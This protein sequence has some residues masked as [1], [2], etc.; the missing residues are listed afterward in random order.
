LTLKRPFRISAGSAETKRN[1]ILA[2]EK[3][4]FGEAAGSIYYGPSEEVIMADLT[5]AIGF[6]NSLKGISLS[7]I[8]AAGELEIHPVCR[9]ALTAAMLNNLSASLKQ[10][11]WELLG[12]NEPEK[13]RTSFTVGIDRPEKM[14]AEIRESRCPIIKIKMGF[15]E[16]EELIPILKNMPARTYRI[17][18]NGGWTLEKAERM[19]SLL[20]ALGVEIVEQPTGPEFT[21]E[22]RHLKGKAKTELF[23]DEGLNNI[24]DYFTHADFL[25]G[26][27]IKMAKCGGSLEGKRLALQARKDG[28]RVMLGCMVESSIGIAPAVFLSS[29]A[30]YCDLD[31]PLLLEKDIATGFEYENGIILIAENI[32]GGPRLISESQK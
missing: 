24:D 23:I 18:A 21:R 2:L 4:S 32:I 9:A 19:I 5:S 29:L 7:E 28:L 15:A 22:W 3:E 1:Y 17:D 6:L 30:D 10:Y 11:P 13:I 8:T 25:D 20:D 16:D 31:G 26:I 27:N 14:A 12:L